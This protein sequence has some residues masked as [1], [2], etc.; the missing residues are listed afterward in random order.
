MVSVPINT[1][2]TRVQR[3]LSLGSSASGSTDTRLQPSITLHRFDLCS[4]DDYLFA[5]ETF[6]VT[7][8]LCNSVVEEEIL[9]YL[10]VPAFCNWGSTLL[11]AV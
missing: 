11:A 7:L 10:A 3:A 9:H 2:N 5:G 4:E 8:L 1:T 6:L